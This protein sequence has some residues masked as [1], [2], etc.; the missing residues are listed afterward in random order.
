MC[1]PYCYVNKKEIIKKKGQKKRRKGKLKVQFKTK[2]KKKP[3][4]FCKTRNLQTACEEEKLQ[5]ADTV[6]SAN[7]MSDNIDISVRDY[8]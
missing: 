3:N 4:F 5:A 1:L 8:F 6:S 7:L 2:G